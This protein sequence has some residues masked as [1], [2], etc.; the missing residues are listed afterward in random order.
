M[1]YE[2]SKGAFIS[3]VI[4]DSA[5]DK[6]GLKAGDIITSVNGKAINTFGELRA[7]VATLGAGKEVK[8]GILRDGKKM[9]FD[10]T[11]GEQNESKTQAK[12]LHEG[13]AGA[14]LSNT[15]DSDPVQGVKITSVAKDSAAASYQIEEGDIIIGVNRQRVTNIAELR[16]ILEQEPNILALNIQRGERSIYLVIR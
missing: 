4:P 1:G 3:Q 11:L 2:S 8:L 13:L 10:V 5:A 9:S 7:K 12:T 6:A 16:K 15:T 14:E